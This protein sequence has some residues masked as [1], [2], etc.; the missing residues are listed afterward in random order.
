M[1][2]EK[3]GLTD[4]LIYGSMARGD[5][6]EYSDMDL[7]VSAP[8]DVDCLPLIF[9][10]SD[11]ERLLNRPVDL[12]TYEELMAEQRAR[13]LRETISLNGAPVSH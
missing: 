11:A 3:H 13:I 6:D 1:L 8:P 9:M 4:L 12:H 7:L 5:A 2:A 10:M